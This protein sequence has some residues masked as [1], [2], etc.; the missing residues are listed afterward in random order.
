MYS[1]IAHTTPSPNP[2]GHLVT[3]VFFNWQNESTP[4]L[5]P[6]LLL[7]E[8]LRELHFHLPKLIHPEI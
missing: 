3:S 5:A 7:K 6:P 1:C 8:I 2:T 4:I